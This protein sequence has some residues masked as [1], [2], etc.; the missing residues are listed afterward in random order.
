MDPNSSKPQLPQVNT[1]VNPQAPPPP[2]PQQQQ[3][4]QQ[5]PQQQQPLQQQPQQPPP[6]QQQQPQL[7]LQQPPQ[8]QQ[9]GIPYQQPQQYGSGP[10]SPSNLAPQVSYQQ[11]Q[12][13]SGPPSP[14]NLTAPQGPY[15]QQQY[16]SAPPSPSNSLAPPHGS[17]Q[18]G[19]AQLA[20]Y[21]PA[22]QQAGYPPTMQQP[23]P[24]SPQGYYQG[25]PP[26]APQGYQYPPQQQQQF[27][28]SPQAGYAGYPPQ[29]AGYP[30]QQYPPQQQP[31]YGYPPHSPHYDPTWQQPVYVTPTI[32]YPVSAGYTLDEC[33][34]P[35]YN[36]QP[37]AD[38]I[39]KALTPSSGLNNRDG[40]EAL[41]HILP[42]L[43]PPQLESIR[44]YILTKNGVRV[45]DL[46]D[47]ALSNDFQDVVRA[48]V[49]GPLA[50]DA[51]LL[52][53]AMGGVVYK[54]VYMDMVLLGRRNGDVRA[55]EAAYYRA[56]GKH[57][58][59]SI[60]SELGGPVEALFRN[61]IEARRQDEN[62]PVV[63]A[64]VEK[65]V[66]DLYTAMVG[67]VEAHV[68]AEILVTRS[69]A[70]IR[71]ITEL[72]N[73]K[74]GVGKE[75]KLEDV[76]VKKFKGH[77]EDA[78]LY[79]VQGANNKA[80]RDAR[81][82]ERTMKGVGTKTEELTYRIAIL[83]WDKAHLE[84]VKAAYKAE[85]PKRTDLITRVKGDTSGNHGKML[86]ALIA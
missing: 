5:P 84:A 18:P 53:R 19:Y 73:S 74:Y 58:V 71:R 48:V 45:L 12:Y 14:L 83:H 85:F 62:A 23:G 55:I 64:A 86:V 75:K 56:H 40:E 65:D 33:A 32:T 79:I 37:D 27:P 16:G 60:K 7:Q 30:P 25:Y 9:Q 2:Q 51:W 35:H 3:Q 72:Y 17:P 81:M 36:P 78:L 82:L 11:Q 1:Q 24:P 67:S 44:Q 50:F 6:Q 68:V 34:P 63:E 57:L 80:L 54:S 46:V 43:A 77:M 49:L 47:K 42:F 28:P 70:Q 22:P 41:I 29:Y 59:E 20:G 69:D 21:S 10:P 61:A 31:A 38:V 76:I 4:Q 39:A 15:Q 66:V 26:A 13:G 52:K 8:Q